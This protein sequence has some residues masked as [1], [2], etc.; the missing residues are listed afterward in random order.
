MTLSERDRRALLALAISLAALLVW[1]ATSGAG[2]PKVV[3]P[4]VAD[5]IASGE[6][7]LARL[8]QIA[9][10]LPKKEEVLAQ[11]RRELA[12]REK[13]LI[14]ADTAAQAQAQV[15]QILR[16]VARAQSPALEIRGVELG[17]LT[18]VSDDYGEAAVT[19]STD[20]RIDQLLNFLADLTRQPEL[21]ATNEIQIG[22]ADPKQ[23]M[24][25]VR[26]TISGLVRKAL[27]PE[28]KGAA[29]F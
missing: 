23:K 2:E 16:R 24:M 11:A 14:Q 21:L 9:A 27:I 7:R 17:Q 18:R 3:E 22:T 13:G 5:S 1:R 19:I 28:K 25:P 12:G 4:V 8:R 15:V 29:L 20:C 10:S 6:R 26:L